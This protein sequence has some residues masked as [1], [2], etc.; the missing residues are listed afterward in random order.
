MGRG[1][2]FTVPTVSKQNCVQLVLRQ[3]WTN[4]DHKV[5]CPAELS[6]ANTSEKSSQSLHDYLKITGGCV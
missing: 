1:V 3:S 2:L 5:H 6:S 4:L